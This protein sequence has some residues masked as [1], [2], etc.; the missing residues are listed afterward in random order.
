MSERESAQAWSQTVEFQLGK[1]FE[2]IVLENNLR[3]SQD[4]RSQEAE[5]G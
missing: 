5:F 1:A 2:K 4:H 3:N